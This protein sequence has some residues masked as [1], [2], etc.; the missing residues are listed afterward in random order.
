LSIGENTGPSIFGIAEKKLLKKYQENT[1]GI[2]IQEEKGIQSDFLINSFD[3][4]HLS[5][6]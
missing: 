5:Q 6:R 1:E 4:L 2:R 3:A